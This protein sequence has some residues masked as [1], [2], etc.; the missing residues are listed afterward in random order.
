MKMNNQRLTLSELNVANCKLVQYNNNVP[1][2]YTGLFRDVK[3]LVC[4]WDSVGD[5]ILEQT[6][7]LIESLRINVPSNSIE[8]VVWI[9][10]Y[11]TDKKKKKL[12]VNRC[13]AEEK[14]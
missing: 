7:V 4:F 12:K 11:H 5:E 3:I 13:N 8:L 10:P 9:D 2:L 14:P 1:H 6:K